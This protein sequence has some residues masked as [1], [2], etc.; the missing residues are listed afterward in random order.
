MNQRM[1]WT[2]K[3]SPALRTR[4][5]DLIAPLPAN[6]FLNKFARNVPN[7]TPRNPP[8]CSFASFGIVRVTPFINTPESSRDVTIFMMYII[9][10]INNI[11]VVVPK[12]KVT[13][14]QDPKIFL[15]I[16]ESAAD[17]TAVNTNG[18][19]TLLANAFITFII[20]SKPTFIDGPRRL[21]RNSPYCIILSSCVFDNF[22]LTDELFP[23]ALQRHKTCQSVI[24]E[25]CRK[26]I[27]E[28]PVIFDDSPRVTSVELFVADF[29]LLSCEIDNSTFTP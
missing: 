23:K 12:P 25:L 26:L 24:C 29:N 13:V 19:K 3:S 15:W 1:K 22:T 14:A 21:P 17:A 4:S 28:E 16:L 2:W 11:R 18:I 10:L 9:S 27:S 6:I 20:N 7:N 5:P 8:L